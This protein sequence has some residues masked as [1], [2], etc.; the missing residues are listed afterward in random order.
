MNLQPLNGSGRSISDF[1][2]TAII[3]LLFTGG[4]WFVAEQLSSLR[5]WQGRN[6][7]SFTGPVNTRADGSASPNYSLLVRVSMIIWL[8]TNHHWSWMVDSGAGWCIL[9]N[10][11]KRYRS[12]HRHP[13]GF[14][15]IGNKLFAGDYLSKLMT[16][17][18]YGNV[19]FFDV[20]FGW[21]KPGYPP[22][23][24]TSRS[25]SRADSV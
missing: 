4:T 18:Y 1:L 22:L 3:T 7:S 5:A 15:D 17:R 21:W 6:A 19:N 11:G 10:S 12:N 14:N 23:K 8:I 2:Y 20:S 16:A 9:T 13:R 24:P 25:S